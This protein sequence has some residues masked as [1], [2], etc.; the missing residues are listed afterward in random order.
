MPTI[1][2]PSIL[3]VFF[4]FFLRTDAA[5]ATSE[6]LCDLVAFLHDDIGLDTETVLRHLGFLVM[7]P[8]V[9]VKLDEIKDKARDKGSSVGLVHKFDIIYDG[10]LAPS[11]PP[12][13]IHHLTL[14]AKKKKR[15]KF[16]SCHTYRNFFSYPVAVPVF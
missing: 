16:L 9:P 10:R 12:V 8:G 7:R 15:N 3:F 1:P 14:N 11:P 13:V 2:L 4:L 5:C 6:F